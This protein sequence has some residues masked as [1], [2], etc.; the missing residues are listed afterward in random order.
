MIGRLAEQSVT[1]PKLAPFLLLKRR[2]ISIPLLPPPSGFGLPPIRDLCCLC[3]PQTH[4]CF[5]QPLLTHFAHPVCCIP[6]SHLGLCCA[7]HIA[8]FASVRG[9]STRRALRHRDWLE[10][11]HRS[12]SAC[13]LTSPSVTFTVAISQSHHHSSSFHTEGTAG[14]SPSPSTHVADCIDTSRQLISPSHV[15]ITHTSDSFQ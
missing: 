2:G 13:P 11:W 4:I 15:Y 10:A 1:P 7:S 8:T 14:S 9:A 12:L 3:S 5:H 6:Q